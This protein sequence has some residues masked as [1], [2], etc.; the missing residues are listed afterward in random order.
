MLQ[1]RKEDVLKQRMGCERSVCHAESPVAGMPFS[2]LP[3]PV[4]PVTSTDP[5]CVFPD[6]EMDAQNPCLQLQSQGVES[7]GLHQRIQ[8]RVCAVLMESLR[9]PAPLIVVPVLIPGSQGLCVWVLQMGDKGA[10]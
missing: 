1:E 10:G 6:A 8:P 4:I 9:C 3:L 5:S 7:W 2:M